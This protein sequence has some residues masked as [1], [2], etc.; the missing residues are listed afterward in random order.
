MEVPV[1]NLMIIEKTNALVQRIVDATEVKIQ[2][3]TCSPPNRLPPKRS[4]I[5]QQKS[6]SPQEGFM[7]PGIELRLHRYVIVLADELN[8]TQAA[9]RLHVS[10]PTLSAQIRDLEGEIGAKLFERTRGGQ[11]V[12]LT[13]SGEAFA[14]ESRLALRPCR[15]TVRGS[16]E[17]RRGRVPK[18]GKLGAHPP[19]DPSSHS[20]EGT[21]YLSDVH[22]AGDLLV[23]EWLHRRTC[24]RTDAGPTA[25]RPVT[26]PPRENRVTF[27]GWH[28][29]R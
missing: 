2:D 22:P 3:N 13:A 9:L 12:V 17:P 16:A 10:Q 27:E 8:F 25:R 24:R 5:P 20:F 11:Q 26:L 6:L 4:N 19:I 23:C 14:A 21:T 29:E 7:Y 18:P 28:R 15:S 1:P